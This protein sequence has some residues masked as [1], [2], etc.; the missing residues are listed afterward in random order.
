MKKMITFMILFFTL[1][2]TCHATVNFDIQKTIWDDKGIYDI[3]ENCINSRGYGY[4]WSKDEDIPTIN[5]MPMAN[6]TYVENGYI[7]KIDGCYYWAGRRGEK[8]RPLPIISL[9]VEI[10]KDFDGTV[11]DIDSDLYPHNSKNMNILYE[12]SSFNSEGAPA[13]KYSNGDIAKWVFGY[14]KDTGKTYIFVNGIYSVETNLT[15]KILGARSSMFRDD[16]YQICFW[17]DEE[18]FYIRNYNILLTTPKQPMYDTLNKLEQC[19]KVK[20]NETFLAFKEPPVIENDRTLIPIR[21]LFEQMGADVDWDA[22]LMAATV[23]KDDTAVTFGID[24]AEAKVNGRKVKM[25]VPAQLINGKTMV[26]V[27]FLSESLGYDVDWDA[28]NRIITINK[29]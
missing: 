25:D 1:Q 24:N 22:E 7:S 11:W 16:V 14:N 13:L 17:E 23:S 3:K 18:N 8:G 15:F 26:P 4:D 6:V 5:E 9:G 21:F 12:L 27:R 2:N 28:E 29:D 19:P 20:L 10:P